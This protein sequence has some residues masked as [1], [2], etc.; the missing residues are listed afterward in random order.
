MLVKFFK[1]GIGTSDSAMSYLLS[2]APFV[3]L[4]GARDAEGIV[5]DPAP[6]VVRGD[7][8]LTRRLIN[9]MHSKKH[10]YVSGVLSF[11]ELISAEEEQRI[12]SR[13]EAM[14]FPGL[15]PS[16]Y[17]C[18]WIRHSHNKRSELHFLVPRCE[19]TTGKAL[20][21]RPPHKRT[22]ELYDTYR[23]L[24][25]HDFRFQ[26]PR[27]DTFKLSSEEVEKLRAKLQRLAA[28]RAKYNQER[29]P[30]PPISTP[31]TDSYLHENRTRYA[32][33]G[34]S[35]TRAFEPGTPG[36]DRTAVERLGRSTGSMDTALA[37]FEHNCVGL[38]K[39]A[40]AFAEYAAQAIAG[41]GRQKVRSTIIDKYTGRS[42]RR[43]GSRSLVHDR[44]EMELVREERS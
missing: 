5:R 4:A 35:A 1:H 13:F 19:L 18:L 11:R 44:E 8:D 20:N 14:A 39:G 32:R 7:A 2:E 40:D 6:A 30:S 17:S 25:N 27:V 31:S 34:D 3:Y 22:E 29:F 15:Q 26:D 21:I 41:V 10:R 16:Q 9:Q 12:I 24:I 36:P 43:Q 38:G 33:R 37:H 28:A 23:L 42:G